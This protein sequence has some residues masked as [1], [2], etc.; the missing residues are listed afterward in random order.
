MKFYNS[1]FTLTR[2]TLVV[3]PSVESYNS[4][5][6][7][8]Y[9]TGVI[10]T[11]VPCFFQKRA[12]SFIYDY[13]HKVPQDIGI[14]SVDSYTLFCSYNVDIRPRDNVRIGAVDYTV[15]A[16]VPVPKLGSKVSHKEVSL[17]RVITA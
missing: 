15:I 16:I 5:G 4:L 14:E 11:K 2:P 1:S 10:A 13:E 8:L 12:G 9:E 6:E 17:E 7:P 3:I